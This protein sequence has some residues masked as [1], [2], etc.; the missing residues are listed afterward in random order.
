MADRNQPTRL[1]DQPEP[2]FVRIKRPGDRAWYA[3][4]I[5]RTLGMLAGEI[6]GQATDPLL[7]WHGGNRITK[8]EYETLLLA[9]N[10]PSPF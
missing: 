3:G 10:T 7:I 4:R 6:N 8:D 2:C 5:Y 1:V 9:A